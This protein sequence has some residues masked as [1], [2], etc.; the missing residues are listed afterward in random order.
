VKKK[1][2]RV[3]LCLVLILIFLL[4]ASF[5]R[6]LTPEPNYYERAQLNTALVDVPNGWGTGFAVRRTNPNGNPRLFIW[7]ARHVVHSHPQSKIELAIFLRDAEHRRISAVPLTVKRVW[8][9]DADAALLWVDCPVGMF[10]GLQFDMRT[11]ELGEPVFAV[12]NAHG[13]GYDG[14]V[15][16]GIVSQFGVA[17]AEEHGIGWDMTDL[18]TAAF[19]PGVSGGPVVSERSHN[20]IGIAVGSSQHGSNVYLPTREI[21]RSAREAG[22]EWAVLGSVCPADV[23]LI[24][25]PDGFELMKELFEKLRENN[26]GI[27]IDLGDGSN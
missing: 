8:E 19:Q 22:L 12:G 18:T 26:F 1:T 24:A 9:L 23:D 4:L 10:T 11:P 3:E 15:L 14:S 6:L 27:P 21:L 5:I 13:P 7:T 17:K 2:Q 16:Q 20:V 25:E